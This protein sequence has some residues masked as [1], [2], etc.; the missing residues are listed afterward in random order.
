MKQRLR[1]KKRV[2]EF[3][4][5]VFEVR[6]DLRSGCRDRRCLGTDAPRRAV[7]AA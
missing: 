1:E 6:A 2:G 7:G 4:E 5:L 3:K